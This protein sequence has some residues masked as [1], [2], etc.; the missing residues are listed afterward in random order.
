MQLFVTRDSVCAGDDGDA[1]HPRTF[2]GAATD[3]PE[4][5]V[6]NV[7]AARY[8]PS[9]A[10]GLATWVVSSAVPLAVVAQQWATPRA[11]PL[12]ARDRLRLDRSGGQLRLHFSYFAQQDPEQVLALLSRLRLYADA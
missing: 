6:A 2:P 9:I 11:L 4:Q 5:A 1:P 8:L 7:L 10:G 3:P 12:S